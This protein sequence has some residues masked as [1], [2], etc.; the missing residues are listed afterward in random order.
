MGTLVDWVKS[1]NEGTKWKPRSGWPGG[2]SPY[3][4]PVP[5][6]CLRDMRALELGVFHWPQ[7][8]LIQARTRSVCSN[9]RTI[10]RCQQTM[11][12]DFS[13]YDP[14]DSPDINHR[15]QACSSFGTDFHNMASEPVTDEPVKSANANAVDVEFQLGWWDHGFGLAK[16]AIQ[17]LVQQIRE[18]IDPWPRSYGSA[19]HL[20]WPVWAS[21]YWRVYWPRSVE[22]RPRID[23]A[24][25]SSIPLQLHVGENTALPSLQFLDSTMSMLSSVSRTLQ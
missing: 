23:L 14:V 5:N 6:P 16:A 21:H 17:S 9:C 22:P 25:P 18:Y 20:V 3:S 4:I 11:F 12:F 15:I 1:W 10:E 7:A 8:V 13:L 24:F 2:Y 19:L